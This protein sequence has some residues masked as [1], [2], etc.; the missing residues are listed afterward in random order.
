MQL[1]GEF[2]SVSN[3]SLNNRKDKAAGKQLGVWTAEPHTE[4]DRQSA[5]WQWGRAPGAQCQFN[6]ATW[7]PQGF[8]FLQP[9]STSTTMFNNF[10]ICQQIPRHP[11]FS[12]WWA[13]AL[14]WK[15][16]WGRPRCL[17][18]QLRQGFVTVV[19]EFS[20][21][22]LLSTCLACWGYK[23]CLPII[24]H[25]PHALPQVIWKAGLVSLILFS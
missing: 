23:M 15:L 18:P 11:Q 7:W 12:C 4:Q 13:F 14:K 24:M 9:H 2:Y 16:G 25:P 19:P 17:D 3:L 5:K 22:P 10:R 8:W 6:L 20:F 1:E 21:V